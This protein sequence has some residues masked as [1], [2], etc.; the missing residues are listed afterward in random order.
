MHAAAAGNNHHH[1]DAS[2][3]VK[4]ASELKD[5]GSK[6]FRSGH[7]ETAYAQYSKGLQSLLLTLARIHLRCNL[8]VDTEERC[9]DVMSGG[10]PPSTPLLLRAATDEAIALASSLLTNRSI[11]A[12]RLERPIRALADA[13]AAASLQ[14][15]QQQGT[16][17]SSSRSSPKIAF[18]RAKALRA[19]CD[20]FGD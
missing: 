7:V 8:G 6:A 16:T 4:V 10:V 18:R 20:S 15:Q 11:A 1:D 14:K 9:E 2:S 3:I 12:L 19:W 17:S 13:D 5:A